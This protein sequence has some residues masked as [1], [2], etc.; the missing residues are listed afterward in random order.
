[1]KH[2]VKIGASLLFDLDILR[3]RAGSNRPSAK[4]IA[5][6]VDA[7]IKFVALE[8]KNVSTIAINKALR[9]KKWSTP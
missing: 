1:V 7:E 9:G 5:E 3:K 6:I 2:K 4:Q 8:L